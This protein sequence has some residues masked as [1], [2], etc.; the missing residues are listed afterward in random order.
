MKKSILIILTLVAVIGLMFAFAGCDLVADVESLIDQSKCEHNFGTDD[1]LEHER[2]E[3][4]CTSKGWVTEKCSLCGKLQTTDIPMDKHTPKHIDPVFPTCTEEGWSDYDVCEDCGH[5]ISHPSRIAPLGHTAQVVPGT[6]ATCLTPGVTDGSMCSICGEILIEQKVIPAY[7]HKVVSVPKKD[8]TCT[9][10][11]YT[12]G[13]KCQYC[14]EIY[15]GLEVIPAKG[16]TGH[17]GEECTV[18]EEIIP[19]DIAS[20]LAGEYTTASLEEGHSLANNYIYR[21]DKKNEL[22]TDGSLIF[23]T[24]KYLDNHLNEEGYEMAL[25]LSG[26]CSTPSGTGYDGRGQICLC[27]KDT[28]LADSQSLGNMSS[29]S[30]NGNIFDLPTDM[31]SGLSFY[32]DADYVYFYFYGDV[33][34]LLSE[35]PW[36][37]GYVSCSAT[38]FNLAECT[39]LD[40]NGAV[41]IVY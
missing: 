15:V 14:D 1:A 41:R 30:T 13:Q 36:Q 31:F 32:Q 23:L 25:Y 12:A 9:E 3:A 35:D 38:S 16:H 33:F 10:P 37:I 24:D 11:G 26:T 39:L 22:S 19:V 18:C 27:Q 17:M 7:S 2:V 4:T 34:E 29:S 6:K 20:V 21:V 5:E 8:A 40:A 28:S